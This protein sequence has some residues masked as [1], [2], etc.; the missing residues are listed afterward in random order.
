MPAVVLTKAGA[1][2]IELPSAV[3]ETAILPLNQ[4]PVYIIYHNKSFFSRKNSGHRL[5]FNFTILSF[6][7]TLILCQAFQLF[8][9]ATFRAY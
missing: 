8:A 2:R 3:L 1:E 4:A 7:N 6:L 9:K 5:E